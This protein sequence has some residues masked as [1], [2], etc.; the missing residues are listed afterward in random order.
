M[1]TDGLAE[2]YETISSDLLYWIR[3]KISSLEDRAFPNCLKGI[4]EQ[5]LHFKHYRTVEKPPKYKEKGELE[6]LFF[7]IQ[8]KRKAMGRPGY[9][10]PD[11]L[12]LHDVESH[13]ALLDHAEHERQVALSEELQRQERLEELSRQFERKARL[14]DAWLKDMAALL[15]DHDFGNTPALV[16]AA[17]KKHQAIA[18]DIVPRVRFPSSPLLSFVL[19]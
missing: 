9:H 4:Q 2:D 8:T 11:G 3:T 13:W 17:V 19:D 10:P 7:T 16:V 14:R 1:Q 5:L 18:A 12:L 15:H 6:A